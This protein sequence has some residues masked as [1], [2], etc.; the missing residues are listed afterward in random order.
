MVAT[1]NFE[2]VADWAFP[3]ASNSLNSL[4]NAGFF[5]P[6]SSANRISLIGNANYLR[7]K[8]DSIK[9]QLPYYGERRIGGGYNNND[10]GIVL[11]GLVEDLSLS[12]NEKKKRYEMRFSTNEKTENY[13]ITIHIFPK[14][15]SYLNISSSHRNNI[16]YR[17]GINTLE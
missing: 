10:V 13:Q 7:I 9:A 16:A 5:P 12:Y 2:I 14:N 8:G 15:Q 1:K 17:G 11:D 4:S 3:L 6:G